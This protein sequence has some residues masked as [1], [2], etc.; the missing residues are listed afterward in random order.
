MISPGSE[1]SCRLHS[2]SVRATRFLSSLME[3]PRSHPKRRTLSRHPCGPRSLP[4]PPAPSTSTTSSATLVSRAAGT[5][6]RH[7]AAR[8]AAR[9]PT[10]TRAVAATQAANAAPGQCPALLISSSF[11]FSSSPSRDA[12]AASFNSNSRPL[13]QLNL[14]GRPR[15]RQ[16]A[17]AKATIAIVTAQSLATDLPACEKEDPSAIILRISLYL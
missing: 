1:L 5:T 7:L 15:S 11:F 14:A 4:A 8:W 17:G 13:I 16:L 9:T 12:S 10:T 2:P 3:H 6:A